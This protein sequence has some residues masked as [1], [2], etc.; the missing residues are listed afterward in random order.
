MKNK[1]ETFMQ[2]VI[3]LIF[4]QIIIKLLGLIYTLYLTNREGFEDKGNGIVAAGYHIYAMLLTLSSIG[5]PSA[6]AKLISE[7]I[8][9]RRPQ[10]CT[11]NF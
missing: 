1:K 10:R 4:S 9:V 6:I 3:T 11:Q 2:G 8:A 7:R 5:V